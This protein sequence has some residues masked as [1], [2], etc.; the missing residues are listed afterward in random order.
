[1]TAPYCRCMVSRL[2]FCD[3]IFFCIQ[4]LLFLYSI[5]CICY[6]LHDVKD[7]HCMSYMSAYTVVCS[8][9]GAMFQ[10]IVTC[11]LAAASCC[12]ATHCTVILFWNRA[13]AAVKFEIG[14]LQL[15]N[16]T[17]AKPTSNI[18]SQHF[19]VWLVTLRCNLS[20]AWEREG[21]PVSAHQPTMY[22]QLPP[23]SSSL[24]I[25]DSIVY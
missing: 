5:K 8:V 16:I 23:A 10:A 22:I 15:W 24:V 6:V 11:F 17:K 2:W 3:V 4:I 7:L 14:L 18:A 12:T 1:M 13:V 20:V 19:Q 21:G 25:Y 9:L